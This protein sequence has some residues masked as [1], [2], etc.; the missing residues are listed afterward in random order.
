MATEAHTSTSLG[1]VRRPME[2]PG[3]PAPHQP[4]AAARPVGQAV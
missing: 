1:E 4:Q 3:S 2:R